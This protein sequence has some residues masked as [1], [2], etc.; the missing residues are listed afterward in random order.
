MKTLLKWTALTVIVLF[1]SLTAYVEYH[2]WRFNE[3]TAYRLEK[4]EAGEAR[5]TFAYELLARKGSDEQ[6]IAFARKY[7]DEKDGEIMSSAI[8]L[9]GETDDAYLARVNEGRAIM[10]FTETTLE[11]LKKKQKRQRRLF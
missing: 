8:Q 9:P 11:T 7:I 4:V 5:P 2:M 10:G 6:L 1:L 3:S